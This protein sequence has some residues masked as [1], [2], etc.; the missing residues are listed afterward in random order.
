[1]QSAL[2]SAPVMSAQHSLLNNS[3]ALNR[4]MLRLSTGLRINRG[5]DDPAGLIA[6]ENLRATLSALE[7][8]TRAFERTDS[9]ASV[10]EAA[11][12]EV[13][14]LL[15]DAESLAVASA[16][17]GAMTEEEIAA[18]QLQMDSIIQSVQR[19][20]DT[21][22]FNGKKLLDGGATL[23]AGRDEVQ[24]DSV[25]PT[26]LGSTTVVSGGAT[27]SVDL[28]D[29]ATGGSIDFASGDFDRI[30][31]VLSNARSEVSTLRGQIG[32]FQAN[33][34]RPQLETRRTAFVN[35]SAAESIIRDTDYAFETSAFV[36]SSI[37]TQSSMSVLAMANNQRSSLLDLFA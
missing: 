11:L 4:S 22:Q 33:T 24:I 27:S 28:A 15:N 7:A 25:Q 30:Q 34:I 2:F 19:I 26:D 12:G 31:E 5:A 23:R 21:A 20:S 36:G 1:M 32:A 37:L 8:E 9:V 35:V 10:A 16:N 29:I 14:D 17:T 3:F 13:N 18:N 6:S